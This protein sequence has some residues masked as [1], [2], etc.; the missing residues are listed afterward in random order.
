MV[1]R[2]LGKGEVG[3]SI[4]PCGTSPLSGPVSPHVPDIT[5]W[6]FPLVGSNESHASPSHP[7]GASAAWRI[8]VELRPADFAR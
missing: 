1:E 6:V 3:S 2:T 8:R 5:V 7:A 4:L